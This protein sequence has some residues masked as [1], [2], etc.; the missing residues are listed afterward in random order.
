MQRLVEGVHY[1][2]NIGFRQHAKLFGK[3]LHFSL[4][5]GILH[6]AFHH[7]L[8]LGTLLGGHRFHHVVH[9]LHLLLEVFK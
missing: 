5:A 7:A 1:F 2:Q 3:L 8:E 4:E 9:A 6:E